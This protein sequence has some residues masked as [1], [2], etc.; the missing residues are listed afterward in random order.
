MRPV[1]IIGCPRT[2]S[3]I[4]LNALNKN[5]NINISPE[6][7]YLNPLWLHP[8]FVRTAKKRVRNLDEDQEVLKLLKM[9]DE[10]NFYGSFWEF[11]RVD[12]T[13]MKKIY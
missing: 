9:V 12:I 2:G 10:C 1:F 13:S 4:F 8:D 5:T 7:H 6:I 3:K 11:K